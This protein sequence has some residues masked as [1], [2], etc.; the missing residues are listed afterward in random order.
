MEGGRGGIGIFVPKEHKG[1][2]PIPKA[3]VGSDNA[4][5]LHPVGFTGPCACRFLEV[6]ITSSLMMS[7]YV[8]FLD[9]RDTSAKKKKK[10][11]PS[12][13]IRLRSAK[14]S[15]IKEAEAFSRAGF[16]LCCNWMWINSSTS[17]SP[18]LL[19]SRELQCELQLSAAEREREWKW[20][21][22]FELHVVWCYLLCLSATSS[23]FRNWQ[24]ETGANYVRLTILQC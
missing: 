10:G 16:P 5:S 15:D 14:W 22:G 3:G 11:W 9:L 7:K 8:F 4:A 6:N 23:L 12:R 2:G 20:K 1:W 19:F 17:T 18:P 21:G 13:V 24:E